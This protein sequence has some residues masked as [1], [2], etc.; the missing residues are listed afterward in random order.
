VRVTPNKIKANRANAMKSTGPKTPQGKAWSSKNAITHGLLSRSLQFDSAEE[1]A[2][3]A[4]LLEAVRAKHIP[5][6][7]IE[8]FFV[9]NLAVCLWKKSKVLALELDQLDSQAD[10]VYSARKLLASFP[11]T[12]T[13]DPNG[14]LLNGKGPLG[15]CRQIVFRLTGE[16]HKDESNDSTTHRQN[17]TA[18]EALHQ[19]TP[20]RKKSTVNSDAREGE[21]KGKRSTG[22]LSVTF[23]DGLPN[24]LRLNAMIMR[25]LQYTL[26]WLQGWRD[27]KRG[28]D[29]SARSE[30]G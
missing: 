25:D 14:I 4:Q 30:A 28:M 16:E 29:G 15:V 10:L 24:V 7:P 27:L 20:I 21:L 19:D 2:G 12:G 9:Q 8:E 6:D 26:E 22:E 1:E 11:A 18:W 17:G 23:T 13:F 5:T 3:F